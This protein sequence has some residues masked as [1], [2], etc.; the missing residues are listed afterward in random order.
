MT[1]M[2]YDD[3]SFEIVDDDDGRYSSLLGSIPVVL[4][5]TND[6][7]TAI[8]YDKDGDHTDE[9]EDAEVLREN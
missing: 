9:D 3:P 6:E 4:D 7:P 8:P 2:H 5:E 1:G